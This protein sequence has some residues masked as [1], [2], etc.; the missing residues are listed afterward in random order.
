LGGR[1]PLTQSTTPNSSAQTTPAYPASK[2]ASPSHLP[3][4]TSVRR[5]GRVTT[6]IRTPDSISEEIDG[7]A[8]A[9]A[10][11]ARTKLNMNMNRI[12]ASGTAR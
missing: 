9:E 3:S 8:I 2:A 6:V 1:K 5:T 7:E 11:R 12:S 4:S 10:L